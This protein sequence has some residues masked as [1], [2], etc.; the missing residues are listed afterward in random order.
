MRQII[1]LAQTT[2]A[3][4]LLCQAWTFPEGTWPLRAEDLW[5]VC[6]MAEYA[7][8]EINRI[9]DYYAFSKEL[10]NGDSVFDFD[11]TKLS[12]NTLI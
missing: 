9:G 12:V 5:G 3:S 11:I 6:R 8:E 1:N 2:S 4:Y 7:R 10:C